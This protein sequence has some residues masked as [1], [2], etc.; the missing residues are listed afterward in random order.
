MPPSA[1][2]A[3]RARTREARLAAPE[4]VLDPLAGAPRR[5]PRRLQGAGRS[6]ERA[7]TG[8][9]RSKRAKHVAWALDGQGGFSSRR[10]AA[11]LAAEAARDG[12]SV[13]RT[14]FPASQLDA[15]HTARASKR[16]RTVERAFRRR[17]TVELTGRPVFPR[18]AGRVRAQVWLGLLASSGEWHLRQQL[19]PMR[20]DDEEPEGAEA[21]RRRL[22]A[23][24]RKSET[25]QAQARTQR[26]TEGDPGH[27]FPTLLAAL[28]PVPRTTVAPHLPGAEPFEVTTRPTPL[29]HKAFK[30]LGVRLSCSQ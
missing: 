11:S 8:I 23:P 9:G 19:R 27:S 26:P 29:Q 13:V 12:L 22:V 30:L 6:G 10:T 4:A 2:G 18:T 15:P 17:K 20:F 7:G 25:A 14:R 5:P 24:A 16:L 1:G 3:H 28:A 21:A